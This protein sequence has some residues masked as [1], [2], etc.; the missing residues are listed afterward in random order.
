MRLIL[1]LCVVA[2][3]TLCG[4]AM[5]GGVRR[6]VKAL[7]SLASGIRLLRVHMIGMFQ[8]VHQALGGTECPLL[9]S[10]SRA[11]T[12][13][14]SAASAWQS[15]REKECRRGRALD[16]LTAE[17]LEALDRLFDGLGESG[18]DRQEILLT[19]TLEALT[20]F[21]ESARRRAGEADR[22]YV[23]LGALTGLMAALVVI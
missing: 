15:V 13:G 3:G 20:R 6:R 16:A 9:E 17:D 10:V 1:A 7:E 11:M 19:Q 21:L 5:S 2:G 4:S 14:G 12:P 23:S 8:P 18:R 22:L